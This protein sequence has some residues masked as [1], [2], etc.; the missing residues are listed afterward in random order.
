VKLNRLA[1]AAALSCVG[2][3]VFAQTT[4]EQPQRQERIEVTG[5]SIKRV[6]TEGALPVQVINREQLQRS[7]ISTAEQLIEQIS[8]NGNGFDN[9]AATADVVSGANRGNNGVSAA[10]LRSTAA[11]LRRMASMAAPSI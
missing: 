3:S 4:T 11:G 10:N 5:S 1:Q 2:A 8:T 9:L 6:Q 7:G